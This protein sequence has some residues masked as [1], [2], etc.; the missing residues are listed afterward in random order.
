MH[1]APAARARTLRAREGRRGE[2]TVNNSG[3]K[4]KFWLTGALGNRETRLSRPLFLGPGDNLSKVMTKTRSGRSESARAKPDL[5]GDGSP[6]DRS[7]PAVTAVQ[8][9]CMADL[10]SS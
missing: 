3:S 6:A 5:A 7:S 8:L 10:F 1:R 9:Y 2:P 4:L